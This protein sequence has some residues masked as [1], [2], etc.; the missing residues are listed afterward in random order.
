MAIQL[1]ADAKRA[2]S[3]TVD[4]NDIIMKDDVRGRNKPPTP[5]KIMA[6]AQSMLKHGQIQ[7]VECRKLPDNRLQLTAGFTRCAAAR[8]I[9]AGFTDPSGKFHQ[10]EQFRLRVK[11]VNCND[12]EAFIR[13]IVENKERNETTPIDDAHNHEKLRR[14]H[15]LNDA[16]IAAELDESPSR[17]SLLKKLLMLEDKVQDLVDEGKLSVTA[18]LDLLDAPKEQ[19]DE[20]I[21]NSTKEGNG[22]I[23]STKVRAQVRDHHLADADADE[24]IAAAKDGTSDAAKAKSKGGKKAKAGDDEDG[25]SV[26]KPRNMR[27]VKNFFEALSQHEDADVSSFAKTAL[28]FCKGKKTAKMFSNAIDKLRKFS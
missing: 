3:W 15:G 8:L 13:N 27:E 26:V 18:A 6:R 16:Q 28:L 7:E 21:A 20:I 19:H 12:K 2:D 22:K 1:A 5:E 4:P 14:N 9:R 11:I 24:Q 23:D 17:I 10:D 25:P